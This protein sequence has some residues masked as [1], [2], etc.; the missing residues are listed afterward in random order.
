[1]LHGP[2]PPLPPVELELE[3]PPEPPVDVE[4][5]VELDE[6][7]AVDDPA[8]TVVSPHAA[9][10]KRSDKDPMNAD[11]L[12]IK[13]ILGFLWCGAQDRPTTS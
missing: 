11:D 13:A 6:E 9:A 8:P 12:P 4:L 3:A 2:E 7:L 10:T 1:M 5:D